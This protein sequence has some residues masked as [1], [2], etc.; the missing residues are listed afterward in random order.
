[1][2]LFESAQNVLVHVPISYYFQITIQIP[3][4]EKDDVQYEHSS[5]LVSILKSK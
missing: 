3:I 5:C 1:M 4:I 2:L